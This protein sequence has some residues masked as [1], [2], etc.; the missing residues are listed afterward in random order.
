M[1][2]ISHGLATELIGLAVAHATFNTTT[3]HPHRE[4]VRVVIP[5]RSLGVFR[6]RLATELTTPNH[7]RFIEKPALFE[8]L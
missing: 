3:G 5:S 6:C 1:E 2:T 7:E 8:V 4:A